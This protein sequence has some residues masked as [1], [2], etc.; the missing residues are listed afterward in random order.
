[1][2]ST[3]ILRLIAGSLV[4]IWDFDGVLANTRKVQEDSYRRV[5]DE[6]GLALPAGTLDSRYGLSE[7]EV[8]QF[9]AMSFGVSLPV[10]TLMRRRSEIYLSIAVRE[11]APSYFVRPLLEVTREQ[12]IPNLVVS[13]GSYVN[14]STLLTEWDLASSFREIYC[15]GSPQEWSR[16]TKDDRIAHVVSTYGLPGVMIEDDAKYLRLARERG[17]RTIGVA[18]P[19]DGMR[20]DDCDHLL[21]V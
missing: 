1:V 8:W 13:A 9:L 4:I 15:S 6:N 21:K 11:L 2:P 16:R 14:V 17:L 3:Q 5:L 7:R 12:G 10:E 20:H 18:H 19:G